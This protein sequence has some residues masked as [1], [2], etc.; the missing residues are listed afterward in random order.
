MVEMTNIQANGKTN[1]LRISAH[2]GQGSVYI[3]LAIRI[4]AKKVSGIHMKMK[5]G[6]WRV[7]A[8]EASV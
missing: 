6:M 4:G 8:C 1:I 7:K 3:P 2:S 5:M